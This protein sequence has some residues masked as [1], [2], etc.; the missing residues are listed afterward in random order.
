[1]EQSCRP[2]SARGWYYRSMSNVYQIT[3]PCSVEQQV[4][5]T[6]TLDQLYKISPHLESDAGD[7]FCL[8]YCPVTYS[9]FI[10]C[11]NASLQWIELGISCGAYQETNRPAQERKKNHRFFGGRSNDSQVR[12]VTIQQV[13]SPTSTKSAPQH[14]QIPS[15]QVI[16]SAHHGYIYCMAINYHWSNDGLDVN[17]QE[18]DVVTG[19]GDECVKVSKMSHKG[20]LYMSF[21]SISIEIWRRSNNQLSLS[22]TLSGA[23][24]AVLCVAIGNQMIYAGCQGGKIKVTPHPIQLLSRFSF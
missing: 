3:I 6:D 2:E 24:G 9:L 15:S 19:G 7:L 5:S 18:T 17:R 1:M 12:A 13:A 8:S 21:K 10:G 4:W 16:H 14:R 11:Q 22:S 23:E 20:S